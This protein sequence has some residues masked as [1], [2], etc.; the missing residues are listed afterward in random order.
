MGST[1]RQYRL[2][3]LIPGMALV[4]LAGAGPLPSVQAQM[5]SP[6]PAAAEA[7]GAAS[8]SVP[9]RPA[10]GGS[11][12]LK[13]RRLPDAVELVIE[14]VGTTP[15]LQQRIKGAT[16]EGRLSTPQVNG[17]RRGPQSLALPE[18]GLQR[19]DLSGSGTSYEIQVTP[20][21]GLSLQKPVVSADGQSL[22]LSFPAPRQTALGTSRL[23]LRQPGAVPQP[24]YAPPLQPRAVAPPVGDMAVGTMMLANPSYLNI[25]GPS[26]TMTLRNAPARDVLMALSQLGGYGFVLVDE[27]SAAGAAPAAAGGAAGT[28]GGAGGRP[29]SI[30]FRNENYSRAFNSAL[31]AAGLQGKREGNMIMAGPNV[32]SKTFGAT[33]SK[34][35]RLNQVSANA[36]ADYL[37]NLGA[38]V[39]KVN[40]ITTAVSEGANQNNTVAGAPTAATTQSSTTTTIE[41][42]G[43]TQGPLKGL[44]GTTDTRLGTITLVGD[45]RVVAVAENYLRQLDLRQ[46]QVALS[47]KIL[48]VSLG[49]EAV[50]ENSFA[51]RYGNNFIVNDQGRLVAAF[52]QYLPPNVANFTG[53]PQDQ[54]T[55]T[56]TQD[57]S[58]GSTRNNSRDSS[59]NNSASSGSPPSRDF[60]D[61]RNAA[62]TRNRDR[63][64]GSNRS[65]TRNGVR[66][67]NPGWLYPQDNFFDF[68]QSVIT[69]S[70]T[71]VLA[72]PT[73]ILSENQQELAGGEDAVTSV[74]QDEGTTTSAKIGRTRANESFVT[75]GEQVI[76][77]Y[78]IV[79]GQNQTG[80][81]C[82]PSFGVAGLTFGARVAKIDDNGF[83]T[84]TMSPQISATTKQLNIANCGLIDILAVRRLDTGSVRVRDGQ[85]LILTGVISDSDRQVVSKWPILG[86]V[87]L[88]GQFFRSS[89]G[90]REKRELVIMVTPRILND[91]EDGGYGYGYR[92]STPDARQFVYGSNQG[93]GLY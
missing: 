83:V 39:T 4:T 43:S 59:V 90:T 6:S 80:N 45:P 49:N 50:T 60:N 36:A 31:L 5:L 46:R 29:I 23:D 68:V 65:V 92:P 78:T 73:L 32:L 72:S 61:D 55:T 10:P 79:Q 84:F 71:K 15:Q 64:G 58:R 56:T 25:S 42:Y 76:T 8:G 19:V 18:A 30:S 69:S 52:G 51:F 54:V 33:L 2:S 28:A 37:A 47:V 34:V 63:Q 41:S 89:G 87:P 9:V 3:R 81:S 13:L 40:T 26:V 27:S 85:T 62:R 35:Y 38:T 77:N 17:L 14:G 21:P 82:Q 53:G 1:T 48:D 86:D 22:I 66:R 7:S 57:D 88:I 70:S 12:E 93:S 11:L 91:S 67:P 74:S 44:L 75:V 16:W 24:S 20:M